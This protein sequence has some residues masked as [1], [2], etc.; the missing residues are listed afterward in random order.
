MSVLTEFGT[1]SSWESQG[2]A[3]ALLVIVSDLAGSPLTR[4]PER[5]P[6]EIDA[7]DGDQGRAAGVA[8]FVLQLAV[9]G[10]DVVL[11]EV[12]LCYDA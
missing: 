11:A 3:W 10:V 2:W 1:T 5:Q 9:F 6:G 8:F 12:V 4:S 7:D